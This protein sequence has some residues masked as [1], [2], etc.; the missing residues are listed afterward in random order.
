VALVLQLS[1]IHLLRAPDE[2]TPLF[3]ALLSAL[4][5][6]RERYRR[7]PDLIV[8]T[9]DVFESVDLEPGR[10]VAAF[11][12]LHE[13]VLAVLGASIPTILI[14][15]NHDRRK[16]GLFGPHRDDL[17][18]QL[19][20][21]SGDGLY[22]HGTRTPF[23][24]ALVPESF[25]RQPFWVIAYDSTYLPHGYVSAGGVLRQEDLLH[26][27][28]RI[29]GLHPDWPVLFLLHHHLVPTPLT[30][31]G[32][33]EAEESAPFV[34]WSVK[35]LLPAI[36]ANADREE[37]TMTA[38]GAGTA[39]S[40][41]HSLGRA[42]LVL[43][44]HKH[45]ATARLLDGMRSGQGDILIVSAGSCGVAQPWT[46]DHEGQDVARLWPSFNVIELDE[47][48]AVVHTVAFGWKGA[49]RGK[50]VFRPLVNAQRAGAQWNLLPLPPVL[51]EEEGPV[52]DT[53]H[54]HYRLAPSAHDGGAR[55]DYRCVR[56]VRS[57]HGRPHRYVESLGG[58]AG[59]RLRIEGERRFRDLP[60][61]LE[62]PLGA[63]VELMVQGGLPRTIAESRKL[64]GD[65]SPPF[66]SVALMNRYRSASTRLSVDGLGALTGEVF[67]SVTDLGTGL[68]RPAR[69]ELQPEG[70]ARVRITDCPPRSLIRL[71][72]PLER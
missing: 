66:V 59:A 11:Q 61:Q 13:G 54:A 21:A 60:E 57:K 27:A 46:V 41:L 55:W 63:P 52:L 22:V 3:D 49:S 19:A 29:D 4:E 62:L 17:F 50:V 45:Y 69:V 5:T 33:I 6:T 31:V 20:R 71:Y 68:E 9:G 1:D 7:A 65:R 12:R 34:Q 53:N 16:S 2:Q 48:R 47:A 67:A 35:Q 37:L 24:S 14:P 44:G 40:T 43:H 8:V 64:R 15:G 18:T 58:P 42:V 38:L 30:D 72:W 36:V 25:H 39:L 10:A 70:A 32:H 23:L 51:E 28:S 56:E 26:A